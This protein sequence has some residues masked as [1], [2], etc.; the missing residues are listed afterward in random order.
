MTDSEVPMTMWWMAV[1][2]IVA[3]L[4]EWRQARRSPAVYVSE[5]WR[6]RHP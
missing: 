5:A 1:E 4:R 2:N 3:R 6:V